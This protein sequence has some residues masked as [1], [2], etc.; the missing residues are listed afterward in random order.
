MNKCKRIT[1]RLTENE[2]EIIKAYCTSSGLT[3]AA[4]LRKLIQ[5]FLLTYQER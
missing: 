2:E 4:F 3:Q 5:L 1:F